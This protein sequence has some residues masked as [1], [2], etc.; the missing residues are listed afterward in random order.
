MPN[1]G[2]IQTDKNK[3][4]SFVTIERVFAANQFDPRFLNSVISK[5]NQKVDIVKTFD[6]I[7]TNQEVFLSKFTT[8]E[9]LALVRK[10]RIALEA[11]KGDVSDVCFS[12]DLKQS[13][14][15]PC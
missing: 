6:R 2:C 11:L 8:Q 5:T 15:P 14:I 13:L 3:N 4:R 1:R 7:G 12:F 9:Q 10:R